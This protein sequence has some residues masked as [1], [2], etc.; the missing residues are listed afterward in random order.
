MLRHEVDHL[1][2]PY[3][4][5]NKHGLAGVSDLDLVLTAEVVGEADMI[6]LTLAHQGEGRVW[7]LVKGDVIDAVSSIIVRRHNVL[8][9]DCI[10]HLLL[11]VAPSRLVDFLDRSDLVKNGL[12]APHDLMA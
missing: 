12:C 3:V 10:S 6:L 9:Y 5:D 1:L 11:I 2:S 7:S 4:E 8:A